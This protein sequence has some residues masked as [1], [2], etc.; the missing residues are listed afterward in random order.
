MKTDYPESIKLKLNEAAEKGIETIKMVSKITEAVSCDLVTE[1]GAGG[2][3]ANY[4]ESS[5]GKMEKESQDGGPGSGRRP[6]GGKGDKS[7]SQPKA[8]APAKKLATKDYLDAFNDFEK[9]GAGN[10]DRNGSDAVVWVRNGDWKKA[11]ELNDK[12]GGKADI[13][14]DAMSGKL[15]MKFSNVYENETLN[16]EGSQMEKEEMKQADG[17]EQHD[18]AAQDVELIKSMLKKAFGGEEEPSAEE[19]SAAKEAMQAYEE[20]GHEKE[21]AGELAMEFMKAAKHMAAKQAKKE[22]EAEA[23]GELKGEEKPEGEEMPEE[24]PVEEAVKESA[25]LRDENIKLRGE[26]AKYKEADKKR[27]VVLHIEKICKESKKSNAF[28]TEF[29][30]IVKDAKSVEEVDR[31]W[32]L[33]EAG[34]KAVAPNAGDLFEGV[35]LATEKTM[36]FAEG[37]SKAISFDDCKVY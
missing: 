29:K 4:L 21:K 31:A 11:H 18:D 20:M 36:S 37:E 26:L 16:K 7:K 28:T 5:E 34:S 25:K 6:G 13:K 8:K 30:S 14:P 15:I 32:K 27:T 19:C 35:T 3:V 10:F 17:I 12:L 9:S 33:F 23:E 1:A 2:S 22:S 24:K